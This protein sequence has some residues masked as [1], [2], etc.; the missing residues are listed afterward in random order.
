LSESKGMS[1]FVINFVSVSKPKLRL[2]LYPSNIQIN[3]S[4]IFQMP[5]PS[6]RQ[7]I[8]EEEDAPSPIVIKKRKSTKIVESDSDNEYDKDNEYEQ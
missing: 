3:Y 5:R 2:V 8:E 4:D 1:R 6:K 7:I